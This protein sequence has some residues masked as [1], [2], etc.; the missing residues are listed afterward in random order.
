M[1]RGARPTAVV[2]AGAGMVA[3]AMSAAAGGIRPEPAALEAAPPELVARLRAD[4]FTYFRF[5]NRPWTARACREVDPL[6]RDLPVV[7]LHGDAHVEQYSLTSGA[8][9]LDDFDDSVR[10]P[11]FLDIARFLGSVDLAARQ[12]GW[13]RET[14]RLY[15]RFFAGYRQ[16]LAE[17]D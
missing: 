12:R 6:R 4:P 16:G 3:T 9:G 2:L 11:A 13:T 17:P 1:A 5:L 7:Q 14:D 8:W 10:G 15:D